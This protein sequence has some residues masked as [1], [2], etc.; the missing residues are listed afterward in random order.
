MMDTSDKIKLPFGWSAYVLRCSF[1]D[2]IKQTKEL[3]IT[4]NFQKEDKI[5]GI[6][7]FIYKPT[8]EDSFF[9]AWVNSDKPENF[10]QLLHELHHISKL[11]AEHLEIEDEEFKAYL[12]EDICK[13]LKLGSTQ[14]DK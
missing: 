7:E 2:L 3:G 13:Q 11:Y 14:E 10:Y 5:Q 4:F 8:P 1:E 6:A 9:I 12:F